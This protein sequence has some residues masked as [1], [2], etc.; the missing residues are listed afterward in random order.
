MLNATSNFPQAY[1]LLENAFALSTHQVVFYF[2]DLLASMMLNLNRI[3]FF[4]MKE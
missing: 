1:H 3:D 2:S 4:K